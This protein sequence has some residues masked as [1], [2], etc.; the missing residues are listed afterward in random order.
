VK[1]N[2]FLAGCFAFMFSCTQAQDSSPPEGSSQ[3]K[4]RVLTYT[5]FLGKNS[6]GEWFKSEFEAIHPSIEVVFIEARDESG[7]R[8]ELSRG[9]ANVDMVVGLDQISLNRLGQKQ[10]VAVAKISS[11]PMAILVHKQRV[12]PE[13]KKHG[14]QFKSWQQLV[15]SRLLGKSLV[16]QDPR[17]STPGLLW[18]LQAHAA[19]DVDAKQAHS[20]VHRV[21]P[22]WTAS[23]KAFEEGEGVAIWTYSSSLSYFECQSKSHELAYLEVE[24]GYLSSEE[25]A[26]VLKNSSRASIALDALKFLVSGSAQKKM[27]E[28]NWVYPV[29]SDTQLSACYIPKNS[30]RI[31]SNQFEPST[32]KVKEW[33]DIWQLF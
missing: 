2:L 24:E 28:L 25:Y 18:L 15:S 21:L 8:G 30:F 3:I 12:S 9:Q 13:L 14:L 31:L 17:F 20:I 10:F 4:L 26:A 32:Q 7:I 16:V 27:V 23:F 11:S 5:S 29:N 19:A 6:F 22:S 33:I 1:N